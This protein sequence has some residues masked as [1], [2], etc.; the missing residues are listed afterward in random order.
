MTRRL[1]I[2]VSVFFAVLT[3]LLCV[4][5]LRSYWWRDAA[6]GRTNSKL[7]HAISREGQI[8]LG[9]FAKPNYPASLYTG[10]FLHTRLTE[11]LRTVEKQMEHLET[12]AKQMEHQMTVGKSIRASI[13]R[14]PEPTTIVGFGL[15]RT[16]PPGISLYVPYWF[17]V[18]LSA[19]FAAVPWFPYSRRFSLRTLLILV[20][21]LAVALG[22]AMWLA[23]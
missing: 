15:Y 12:M 8:E 18:L 13:Q 19:A 9:R 4:L 7:I 14:R 5:W 10:Q 17:L 16:N 23:A 22:L 21:L 2:A 1:R 20:T 6:Y 11:E 3:V